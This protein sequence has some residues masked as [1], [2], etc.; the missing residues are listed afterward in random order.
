[1]RRAAKQLFLEEVSKMGFNEASRV[2]TINACKLCN[3]LG[4][5]LVLRGIEGAVPLLH[6][7]QGCATYIRRYLISH[8][9][10]PIDVASSSFS[11]AS[12]I[13]GGGSNLKT[14]LKN[15]ITQYKPELIGIATTCLSETIGDD[16]KLILHQ[17]KQE[18]KAMELPAI[19]AVSTP[20]YQ[21]SHIDGFHATVRAVV[22]QLAA[23]GPRIK[24]VNLFTGMVSAAD[25]RILKEIF[26]DFGMDLMM[27]PDYS[28]TMD[29]A[30]WDSYQK[31]APGGAGLA[32][33]EAAGRSKAAIQ[34]GW[35]VRPEQNAAYYLETE[36]EIKS[37][38][39]G[40]PIG[41][42]ETDRFMELLANLAAMEIP[43]KY[44]QERGRLVDSYIDGH[45]YL[46]GKKAAI[47]GE[48][49]LV[50]GIAAFL[51][52]I[53]VIPVLCATGTETGRLESK[54]NA[55]LPELQAQMKIVEGVDFS[56]I[57]SLIETV[58]P[59]LLIGNSK[60]YSLAR[61][62][63]LPLIRVG[64][65]IH[66]RVGGQRLLHLGYRGTQQL[67]D[68]IVNEIIRERQEKSPVGWSYI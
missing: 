30:T 34:L 45:K 47:Y 36:F 33:I 12:T 32:K 7:S 25:L 22:E 55:L 42:K 18:N 1:L 29:G 14:A 5:S 2:A 52:E 51:A 54:L 41:I 35:T 11:E 8:F 46:F 17:F 6:G 26:A 66:D 44:R 65:P 37:Y 16:V 62:F 68:Q 53:G 15:V 48:P 9:K 58:Q 31:I 4:A 64:F 43:L 63:A 19:V 59:D 67:F 28:E 50:L 13:F 21:G 24:Q 3:P 40:L 10:E 23:A 56:A 57:E 38:Q 27:L 49:D 20:S 61:K 60:G 39:L